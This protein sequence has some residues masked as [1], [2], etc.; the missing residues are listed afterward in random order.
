MKIATILS[1]AL[2]MGLS[3]ATWTSSASA[4]VRNTEAARD[5]AITRCNA[6]AYHRYPGKYYDWG[7]DRDFVYKSCMFNAG[8]PE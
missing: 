2:A 5:A 1:V 8:V 4:A 3:I 6:E 7:A